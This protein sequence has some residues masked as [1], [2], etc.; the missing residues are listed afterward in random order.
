MN[1]SDVTNAVQRFLRAGGVVTVVKPGRA[2]GIPAVRMKTKTTFVR[3][4][5]KAVN[6]GYALMNYSKFSNR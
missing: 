2:A 4:V 5:T 1:S 3:R 6:Q